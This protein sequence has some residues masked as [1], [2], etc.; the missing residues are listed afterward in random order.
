MPSSRRTSAPASAGE[1]AS[2]V[3]VLKK[4]P[5]RRLYDTRTS[6]YI[7]LADV[8]KMVLALSLIHISEPTRPY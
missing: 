6:S 8:K 3:R 5:N 2:P 4:Y 7:T 1:A